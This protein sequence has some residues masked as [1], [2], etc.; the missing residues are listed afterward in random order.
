MIKIFYYFQ[1]LGIV[2]F[3]TLGNINYTNA[4][5]CIFTGGGDGTNWS[6]GANWSCGSQPDP[7]SDDVIIPEGFSVINDT[8][9][10]I[11]FENGFDLTIQGAL[12]ME[13]LKLEFKHSAS[14]LTVGSTG[15][16]TDVNELFFN[17]NAD[18]LIENGA[19]VVVNHL[20]TDDDTELTIRASCV[21]VNNKLENLSA[22]GIIGTGCISYGG[23]KGDFVNT[24]TDGIF[25]CT[26]S[27]YCDCNLGMPLPIELISFT[28]TT[29]TNVVVLRWSTI[30]EV[31]NAFFTLE[32]S[33]DGLNWE[34]I[35]NVKGA[36]NSNTIQLYSFN[37]V[38][39]NTGINYYR[40]RQTD[41]DGHQTTSKI[42][43]TKSTEVG[44]S[45]ISV[46]P[47]PSIDFVHVQG[48][49]KVSQVIL[50][51][52]KGR[53]LSVVIQEDTNGLKIDLM[54]LKPGIYV[55]K[56]AFG[57]QLLYKK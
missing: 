50:T 17:S 21:I 42:V 45:T 3:L 40:L 55:V 2:L 19:T 31:N 24:G 52:A 56:T 1:F 7:Q 43:S 23:T 15:S 36:G 16:L 10:D 32:R 44:N 12:D 28:A 41:A 26:S 51:D 37:D 35:T 8:G 11:G 38:S 53:Q 6:D 5:T 4:A 46:F 47:N 39:P 33:L 25:G 18:G 20:K 13:G 48:V 14:F 22:S 49:E 34:E 9:S 30:K 29:R 57:T 54:G 27:N